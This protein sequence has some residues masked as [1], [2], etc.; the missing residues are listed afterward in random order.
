MIGSLYE[1]LEKFGFSHPLHPIFT[2]LP[3]G[4]IIGMVIFS[5][6]GLIRQGKH[7]NTTAYY[8]SILAFLG[9]F[10]V[11]SAGILDWLQLMEGQ[12]NTFIIKHFFTNGGT[13]TNYKIEDA[14]GNV[15]F[16]KY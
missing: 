10:P 4:M 2:H 9:V 3:M 5:F 16:F 15:V 14:F 1:T 12:W 11:I 6:L 7:F 13:T 8:C